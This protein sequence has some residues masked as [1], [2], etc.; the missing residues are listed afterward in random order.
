VTISAIPLV[1]GTMAVPGHLLCSFLADWTVVLRRVGRHNYIW[2]SVTLS[3]AFITM[4]QKSKEASK[5]SNFEGNGES[6]LE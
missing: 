6:D 1:F 5:L 2:V 4:N 3:N